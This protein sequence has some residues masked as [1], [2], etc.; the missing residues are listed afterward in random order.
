MLFVILIVI[1]II[2][3]I[4]LTVSILLQSSKGGGLSGA[5][6]GLGGAAQTMFGGRGTATFLSK[7]TSI[8]A[9]LFMINCLGMVFAS[10]LNKPTSAVQEEL[11]RTPAKTSQGNALPAVPETK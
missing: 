8:L 7:A 10:G 2:I 11:Q 3:S 1:H 9:A 5:F 6:G 4:L